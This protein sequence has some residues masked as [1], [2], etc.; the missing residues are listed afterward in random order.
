MN[1]RGIMSAEERDIIVRPDALAAL[2]RHSAAEPRQQPS[3]ES[4]Q[5]RERP[6]PAG[7]AGVERER[8]WG[9]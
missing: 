1:E 8:E 7:Q 5:E 2:G 3:Q 6:V 9:A 4:G